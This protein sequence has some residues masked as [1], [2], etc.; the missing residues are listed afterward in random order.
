MAITVC[1][2]S[3]EI[4]KWYRNNGK[5]TKH[6]IFQHNTKITQKLNYV[7]LKPV[8]QTKRACNAIEMER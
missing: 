8:I 6:T 2:F 7:K 1:T 3:K 5:N 4:I